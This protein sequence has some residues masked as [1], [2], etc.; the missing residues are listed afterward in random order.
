M[1]LT[2]LP[3]AD[4]PLRI[5]FAFG[6]AAAHSPHLA[7]AEWCAYARLVGLLE[8]QQESRPTVPAAA[9]RDAR[10]V[11]AIPD[12]ALDI[13]RALDRITTPRRPV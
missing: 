3:L 8:A 4:R 7:P 9:S 1:N 10:A 13:S 11:E 2:H 5:R 12:C 6:W